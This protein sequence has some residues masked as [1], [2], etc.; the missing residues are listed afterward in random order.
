VKDAI[1]AYLLGGIAVS[2]LGIGVFFLGYWRSSRDRFFLFM[3]LSFWIEAV[4]RT[5]MAVTG[6]WSEDAPVN[7]LIRLLSYALILIAIWDKNRPQR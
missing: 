6:S 1:N 4:N 2:C 3:A 5:I 7:Y